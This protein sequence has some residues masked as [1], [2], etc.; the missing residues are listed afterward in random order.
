[1]AQGLKV[2]PCPD[3]TAQPDG[4]GDIEHD[5]SCPLFIAYEAVCGRDGSDAAYFRSHPDEPVLIR[6]VTDAE[7]KTQAVMGHQLCQ[8]IIV[9][10][11]K[12]DG[13]RTRKFIHPEVGY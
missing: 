4:N 12:I 6:P 5:E 10:V 11:T 13:G 2:Q 9:V 1:M 3:C 7:I 8:H